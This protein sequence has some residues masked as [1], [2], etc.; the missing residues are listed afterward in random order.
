MLSSSDTASGYKFLS[1]DIIKASNSKEGQ[2]SMTMST[3][4]PLSRGI[5]VPCCSQ[6]APNDWYPFHK[7]STCQS[8]PLSLRRSKGFQVRFSGSVIGASTNKLTPFN[9]SFVWTNDGEF[10]VQAMTSSS[11][12]KVLVLSAEKLEPVCFREDCGWNEKQLFCKMKTKFF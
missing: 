3:C 8:L 1:I 9:T 10:T 5:C 4:K 6:S 2:K 7:L 12:F 11:V